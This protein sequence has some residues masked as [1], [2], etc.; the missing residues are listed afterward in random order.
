[1]FCRYCGKQLKDNAVVCT[2]CG[3]PVD[4]PTGKKWSIATVLGLIAI[5]VFVPP[6]GLI[7]GVIGI[8][9]EARKVQGAVLLT[10]SI[11]MSLLLLAIVLGL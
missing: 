6:V 8:R 7:F 9:N 5:T 10:V 4:G 2:G 1:M 3:R 11:F